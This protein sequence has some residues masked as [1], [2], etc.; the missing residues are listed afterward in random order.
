[1]KFYFCNFVKVFPILSLIMLVGAC[2]SPRMD[3]LPR[4]WNEEGYIFEEEFAPAISNGKNINIHVLSARKKGIEARPAIIL[5]H[6]S[7]SK[8]RKDLVYRFTY[9]DVI[10]YKW[11]LKHFAERGYAAFFFAHKGHSRS[12]GKMAP[13]NCRAKNYENVAYSVGRDFDAVHKYVATKSWADD[14]HTIIAG[15]SIG[16][17]G[18]LSYAALQ[19]NGVVGVL[20]FAGTCSCGI[21]NIWN[22]SVN[23]KKEILQEKNAP[24]LWIYGTQDK[25]TTLS[26]LDFIKKYSSVDLLVVDKHHHGIM[27]KRTFS[28]K[29]E[30]VKG[31]DDFL[32]KLGM[33]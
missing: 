29:A 24:Q 16:G 22:T 18:A 19:P 27:R 25:L 15:Q 14:E 12:G 4:S 32:N 10:K 13:F 30:M 6:G 2:A 3:N 20:N 17:I 7:S 33:M 9:Y 26:S 21:S 8:S 1:M 11:L 5:T 31:I 28:E 23:W